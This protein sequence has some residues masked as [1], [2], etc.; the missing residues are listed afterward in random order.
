MAFS[1][2]VYNGSREEYASKHAVRGGGYSL[3]HVALVG[4]LLQDPINSSA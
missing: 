3:E 2:E 4:G 1:S